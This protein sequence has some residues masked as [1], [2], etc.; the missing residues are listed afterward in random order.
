MRPGGIT[1]QEIA[2]AQDQRGGCLTTVLME[3]LDGWQVPVSV[4]HAQWVDMSEW[5]A[6]QKQ[7]PTSNYAGSIRQAPAAQAPPSSSA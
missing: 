7:S 5:A 4:G 3:P 2:I 1:A 6:K